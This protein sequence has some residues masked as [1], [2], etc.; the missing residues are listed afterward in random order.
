M[1]ICSRSGS[2]ERTQIMNELRTCGGK[3]ADVN[4]VSFA[5]KRPVGFAMDESL[6]PQDIHRHFISEPLETIQSESLSRA[7]DA[8][9]VPLQSTRIL[10]RETLGERMMGDI[11]ESGPRTWCR[12]EKMCRRGRV[13]AISLHADCARYSPCRDTAKSKQRTR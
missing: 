3:T 2:R 11:S 4:A 12:S 5:T 6:L 8:S 1:P 13:I 10:S 9:E 7:R